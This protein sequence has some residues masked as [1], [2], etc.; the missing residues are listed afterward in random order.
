MSTLLGVSPP[1][2]QVVFMYGSL[3]PKKAPKCYDK[4]NM[5]PLGRE[6]SKY[7]LIAVGFALQGKVKP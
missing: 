3:V 1:G 2:V 6:L 5:D 4:E 7:V